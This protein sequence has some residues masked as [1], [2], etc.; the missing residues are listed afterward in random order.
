V[1]LSR[2][3]LDR[4]GEDRAL[5]QAVDAAL[6]DLPAARI[7]IAVSG[8]GDSVALLHLLARWSAQTGRS[9]AAVTVDHQLRASSRA[10]ADAVADLCAK[11]GVSHD[12]LVWSR[13]AGAGNLAAAARDGRYG[14]MAAWARGSGI[15]CIL[16][17][18]TE[19]DIAENFLMRL[20]RSAGI[21]GLSAMDPLFTR[22]GMLWSRPLLG[23]GR[24]SL[25]DYLGRHGISWAEDPGNDDPRYART[26]A[27]RALTHPAVTDLGQDPGGLRAL[28]IT[29]SRI[30]HTSHA[31]RQ[32]RAAL[33][34]YT[35]LEAAAHVT[36]RGGDLLLPLAAL[37]A[38]PADVARRLG[39]A[40]LQWVGSSPYP[41]RRIGAGG[42]V[43]AMGAQQRL[44]LAG[45][46][47]LRRKG[48][49]HITREYNAVRDLRA[50]TDAIWDRRWRLTGPHAR[51]LEVR[52]LGAAVA[53]LPDWRATGL[54]RPSLMASPA[55][56][57]GQ[58]LIAAPLAGVNPDWSVQIVA[59]FT[60]FLLSH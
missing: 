26:L 8:G 53:D 47:V 52:A 2:S 44:T 40:A 15:G 27:R 7:G 5:L 19:G 56:W 35:R 22:D 54:P 28:G 57:R 21:D 14:L 10:E 16:L 4:Q 33:A 43:A 39:V 32:A 6:A 30:A 23:Q 48:C 59:D 12:T 17:G 9:I 34:H 11:L 55:V 51:D 46:I 29:A 1:Q 3:W 58:T 20:G 49:L 45:C 31:L 25:R 13:P 38:I 42:L 24:Q 50:Q 36:Q 41:P 60:S 37:P 18:H